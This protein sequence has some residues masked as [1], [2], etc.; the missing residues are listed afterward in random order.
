[1]RRATSRSF[2]CIKSSNIE[3]RDWSAGDM[4]RGLMALNRKVVRRLKL[5]ALPSGV[6]FSTGVSAEE[7]LR[8]SRRML[9]IVEPFW[10]FSN[11]SWRI[12]RLSGPSV[13]RIPASVL[14]PSAEIANGL[15][16]A[17]AT[18]WMVVLPDRAG[19]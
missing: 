17:E 14:W 5:I 6:P 11:S 18:V 10:S 15:N 12:G 16:T 4:P 13:W 2:S 19:P 8:A 9:R 7:E 1:M 3:M